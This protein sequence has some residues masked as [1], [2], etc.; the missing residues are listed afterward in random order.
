M[1][2]E[3]IVNI[4]SD[5]KEKTEEGEEGLGR[6][7]ILSSLQGGISQSYSFWILITMS[8]LQS[9][10]SVHCCIIYRQDAR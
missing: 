1:L 2:G 7:L 6:R 10:E 9:K 8:F 3:N 5:F 4:Y